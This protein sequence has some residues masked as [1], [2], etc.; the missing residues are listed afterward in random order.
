MLGPLEG[1]LEALLP[2]YKDAARA[3]QIMHADVQAE[4]DIQNP[5]KDGKANVW[6]F[7]NI[8][9]LERDTPFE[10]DN[11]F[12]V[13]PDVC[14][15]CYQ[16]NEILLDNPEPIVLDKEHPVYEGPKGKDGNLCS[17]SS[18]MTLTER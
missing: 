12:M 4:M 16:F 2:Q 13:R 14:G 6:V 8:K 1:K 18:L 17:P 11:R 10:F 15:H 3:L 7:T 5:F 9:H